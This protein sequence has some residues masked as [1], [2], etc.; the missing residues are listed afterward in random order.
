MT[1]TFTS[2]SVGLLM[3]AALATGWV[4]ARV[5][6]P[7]PPAQVRVSNSIRPLGASVAVPKAERLHERIPQAPQPSRGRNP[8]VYAARVAPPPARYREPAVVE[9]P[10]PVIAMEP[11]APPVP[12]F[13]LSGIASDTNDGVTTL[14]A[15]VSDNGALAFVK[16][17]DRLSSGYT[18]QQVSD[19]SITLVDAAGVA[20]TIR[21]P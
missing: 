16:V 3:M 19:T 8:F 1:S 17:G 14:T 18:V 21:L 2:R 7:E 4:G 9:T 6:A 10:V 15:I 12:T 13:R 20:T 5:T 11:A